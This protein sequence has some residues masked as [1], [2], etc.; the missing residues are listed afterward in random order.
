M[1]VKWASEPRV[2]TLVDNHTSWTKG[3]TGRG[4]LEERNH[5]RCIFPLREEEVVEFVMCDIGGELGGT[6]TLCRKL[7]RKTLAQAQ[8]GTESITEC[9]R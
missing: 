3:G 8:T 9:I 2:S 4:S 7:C 6:S 5:R 1:L